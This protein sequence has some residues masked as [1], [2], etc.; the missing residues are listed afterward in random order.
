MLA[1]STLDVATIDTLPETAAPPISLPHA[2]VEPQ[3]RWQLATRIAFRFCFLYFTLYVVSTQMLGGLLPFNWVRNLGS[4]AFM[5]RVITWAG[6]HVF[7]LSQIPFVP[8]GSGDKLVDYLQAFC[9]LMTAAAGTLV[10]SVV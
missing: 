3:P 10:W 5:R 2:Q 7:H 4:T 6:T 8:S 1:P 9:L